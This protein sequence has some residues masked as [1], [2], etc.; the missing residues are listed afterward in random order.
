MQEHETAKYIMKKLDEYGIP[1]QSG[2]AGTGILGIIENQ[3]NG[4]N[5]VFALRA[6]MDA[7]PIQENS[8]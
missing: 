5:K 7:L 6:D 4:G 3:D 2:I 8:E 1:Y